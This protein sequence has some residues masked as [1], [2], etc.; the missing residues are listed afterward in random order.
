MLP[1]SFNAELNR[2]F[3]TETGTR[4]LHFQ[5]R[6][7]SPAAN[8]READTKQRGNGVISQQAE[9]FITAAVIASTPIDVSAE[10]A[11]TILSEL[12]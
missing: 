5:G 7:T 2:S 9:L 8:Q 12:F 6:R 4:R 11:E 1:K 10:A 3:F